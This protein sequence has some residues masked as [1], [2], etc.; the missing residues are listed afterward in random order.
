MERTFRKWSWNYAK[1]R[2][3][4]HRTN[5]FPCFFW[6][7]KAVLLQILCNI[8]LNVKNFLNYLKMSV[9]GDISWT[10]G[11]TSKIE[12]HEYSQ[13]RSCICRRVNAL[14]NVFVKFHH[15]TIEVPYHHIEKQ[16]PE[17]F[18]EKGILKNLAK[19]TWN[20]LYQILFFNKLAGLPATLLKKKLW[21][22]LRHFSEHF[23]REHLRVT[24][25]LSSN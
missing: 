18:C 22:I 17:I 25:S 21:W 15:I 19:L 6:Y 13:S 4:W 11:R 3:V 2:E 9:S 24:D 12:H 1:T 23:F 16:P 5:I 20:Y 10:S 8:Y 14:H 7:W